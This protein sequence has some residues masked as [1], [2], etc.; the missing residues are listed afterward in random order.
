MNEVQAVDMY[1]RSF[2]VA[3]ATPCQPDVIIMQVPQQSYGL[4]LI[5]AS[6]HIHFTSVVNLLVDHWGEAY[7]TIAGLYISNNGV[8]DLL[9]KTS[10]FGYTIS[11]Y[12]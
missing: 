12:R 4:G 8:P 10:P 9:C 2:T 1:R 7:L 5:Y 3:V 11:V 6:F